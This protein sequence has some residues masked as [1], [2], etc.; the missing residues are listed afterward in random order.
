M[1]MDRR[2]GAQ[3]YTLR[4][5]TKTIEDFEETC[6]KVKEIGYQI[7]Q[8][9]GTPLAAA[10]MREVLDRY[11]LK[12]A[13]TH[14]GFEDFVKRPEEII[15]YNKT[16]G[17]EICGIGSMPGGY[18]EDSEG[19]SRF[20]KEA[21][22]A[23]ARLGEEGLFLGYHNHAFEFARLDGKLIMD[24]LIQET[25]PERVKFIVDTY[26]VQVGGKDPVKFIRNLGERAMAIHFKDLKVNM[27]NTVEFG[28]IGEGSLDWDE[29]IQACDEA[30]AKWALVEQDVCRRDPFVSM[31]MSY[32]YLKTKGFC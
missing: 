30:G 32:E 5:Y 11:G 7:V 3:Y 9:S 4:E 27:D 14:R 10:P 26:W 8:I 21:N 29:I 12:V 17:C 13:V 28:E 2:I 20:I 1:S 25:D 18:R 23:A 19:I 24:R 15:D 31:K 22:E 6:R 16:L